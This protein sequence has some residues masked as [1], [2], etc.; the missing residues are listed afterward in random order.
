MNETENVTMVTVPDVQ[1]VEADLPAVTTP[2]AG[3][4]YSGAAVVTAG[5]TGVV[6]G[7]GGTF[8]T[9]LIKKKIA[10]HRAKK[11]AAKA[12]AEEVQD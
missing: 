1:P 9:M 10:E 6:A 12:E 8:L 3:Y 5:V 7:V 11:E 4:K 2:D